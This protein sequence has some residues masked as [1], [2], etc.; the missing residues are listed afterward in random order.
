[1]FGYSPTV[2]DRSGEITAAGQLQG[3][4]GLA[5]G[6]TTAASGISGALDKIT[7]LKMQAAQA[8]STAALAGQMGII[9]PESVQM[10]QGLPWQQKISIA[11]NMIQM[12]GQ[13]QKALYRNAFL[14]QRQQKTASAAAGKSMGIM[15]WNSTPA[16]GGLGS[17]GGV[18]DDYSQ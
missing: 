7:G 2:Q 3:A 9:D 15:P 18:A 16:P 14:G 4:Q 5:G 6:I 8:D 13:Q 1:M 10:I 11:P 12:I 17:G